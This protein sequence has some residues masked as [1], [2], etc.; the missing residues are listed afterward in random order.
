MLRWLL[1]TCLL[2]VA[3]ASLQH[4][5]VHYTLGNDTVT[6]KV[7]VDADDNTIHYYLPGDDN[8][9]EVE[10]IDDFYAGYAAVKVKTD[11]ACYVQPLDNTLE[12]KVAL[13]QNNAEQIIEGSVNSTSVLLSDDEMEDL[14]DRVVDFCDGYPIYEVF[15]EKTQDDS[16]EEGSSEEMQHFRGKYRD[17]SE[18]GSSEEAQDSS[19]ESEDSSEGDS[20]DSS[21]EVFTWSPGHRQITVIIRKCVVYFC[22]IKRCFVTTL[23]I[24]TGPSI[25]FHW[26]FG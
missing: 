24:P 6:M 19:D 2:G 21:E 8:F 17:S 22:T 14:G 20:K 5:E 16:N 12:E 7:T 10:I 26:L 3:L 13:I 4:L 25:A 15:F 23:T 18:E 11:E 1:S 9:E